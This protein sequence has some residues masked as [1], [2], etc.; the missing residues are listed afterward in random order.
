MFAG[1]Y[2]WWMLMGVGIFMFAALSLD[3]ITWLTIQLSGCG[4][5]A[6]AC[7]PVLRLISGVLKPAC[8]WTAIGILFMAT[9]LRLH[10]L[11]LIWF[12]GPVVAVWFVASTPILLFVAADAAALTQPTTLAVLPVALLFLAAFVTCLMFALED[13]DILPLAASVPLR[14]TLRL[15]AV[16]GALAGAAFMPE[17]S[18]IAGTLLDMP[19]LSVIIALAQPYLQTVLTLGTGSMAPAYVVLAAF[20][21]ALAASLLPHAAAPQPSRSAIMLRRSRR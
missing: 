2:L 15:T 20:I 8:I 3:Y 10:T 4:D 1:R 18:R 12:W 6:G 9:L 7:E 21:A 5:M 16:Y 11:S 17:L 14:L 13:G 19:A